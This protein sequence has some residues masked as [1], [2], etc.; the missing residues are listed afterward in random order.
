MALAEE[1]V[2]VEVVDVRCLVP[3]DIDTL[4]CSARKTRRVLIVEEDNLTAG[5]GAE[6]SARLSEELFGTMLAPIRRVA[7][8]DTPLPCAA[9]L[10]REYVPSAERVAQD[11]QAVRELMQWKN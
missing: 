11:V 7:A 2:D 5:W 4:V 1:G 8:P 10:E 3:L 9:A 6:V